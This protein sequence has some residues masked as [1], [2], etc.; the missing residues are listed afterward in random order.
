V[1]EVTIII[2]NINIITTTTTTTTTI[3]NGCISTASAPGSL[4]SS[5]TSAPVSKR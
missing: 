4:N 2:I 3:I 5:V 1:G